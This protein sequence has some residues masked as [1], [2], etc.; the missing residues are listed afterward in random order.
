[1]DMFHISLVPLRYI[2]AGNEI[3]INILEEQKINKEGGNT[4]QIV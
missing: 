3:F 4:T 2:Y 1:M